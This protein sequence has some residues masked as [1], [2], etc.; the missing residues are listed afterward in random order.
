M[1][2]PA[3][4]LSN[5]PPPQPHTH[6]LLPSAVIRSFSIQSP[7]SNQHQNRELWKGFGA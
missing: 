1:I 6:V 7:L 3:L 4:P 2:M 5:P